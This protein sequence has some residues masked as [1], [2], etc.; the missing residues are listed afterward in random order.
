[1][2]KFL[3]GAAAIGSLVSASSLLA[4]VDLGAFGNYGLLVNSGVAG[5]DINT[6]PVNA[7]IGIGNISSSINLHNGVVNGFVNA[8]GTA[9]SVISG[10][11]ITGTVGASYSGT[12]QTAAAS[13]NSNVAS[14]SQAITDALAISSNYGSQVA[15]A[16]AV[17]FNGNVTINASSGF[18]TS[19]GT[20]LFKAPTFTIGNG[21]TVTVN[22]T[23][24][25]YVVIDITSGSGNKLDGAVTLTGGITSDH[26]ILNFIGSGGNLQGAANGAAIN[27]TVLAPNLG[28][29]L[30]SLQLNGRLF[31]GATGTNF[32]FVSNARIL[33]ADTPITVSTAPEPSTWLMLLGGFGLVGAAMRRRRKPAAQPA[34]GS[35]VTAA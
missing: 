12:G 21:K 8:A 13:V 28:I 35:L 18:L 11:N 9:S 3:L 22:G 5:G 6:F 16:T 26:V 33:Q 14:V 19:D 34:L 25:D 24:S 17:T 31:G 32:Q 20:R 23:A 15:N 10:G 27:A 29:Q 1:M 30:N 4:A 2:K 7:N